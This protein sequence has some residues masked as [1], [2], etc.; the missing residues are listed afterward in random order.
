ML[1]YL[2]YHLVHVQELEYYSFT[3]MIAIPC[4]FIVKHWEGLRARSL[5]QSIVSLY[6]SMR[7]IA[8]NIDT[9]RRNKSA[10]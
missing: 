2:F 8:D 4:N 7:E 9:V 6:V 3:L 10:E 5:Y 1:S